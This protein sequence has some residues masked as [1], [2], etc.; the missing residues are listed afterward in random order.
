MRIIYIL[1]FV[2]LLSACSGNYE[3][4]QK[5]LN[6]LHGECDNPTK[7]LSREN[8]ENAKQ[9]RWVEASLFLTLVAISMT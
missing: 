3:Q 5:R 8:I 1:I 9:K 6:E 4:N 7:I 2:G